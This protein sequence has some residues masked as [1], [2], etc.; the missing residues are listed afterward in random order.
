MSRNEY[1]KRPDAV[2]Y[3]KVCEILR[4]WDPIGVFG[5]DSNCPPDEYDSYAPSIIR[6]LDAGG[7]VKQVAAEL[8]EIAHKKMGISTPRSDDLSIAKELVAF[9]QEL[10]R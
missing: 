6:L 7:D 3:L 5:P 2:G 4:E 8:R 10:K 1:V 9:W